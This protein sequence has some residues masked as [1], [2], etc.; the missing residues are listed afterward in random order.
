MPPGY[1][2]LRFINSCSFVALTRENTN[3][4]FSDNISN[5]NY[6]FL[7]R[8]LSYYNKDIT[9]LKTIISIRSHSQQKWTTTEGNGKLILN[10]KRFLSRLLYLSLIDNK[11]LV[12]TRV[13]RIIDRKK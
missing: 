11:E 7:I 5:I 4:Q 10:A 6:V 1:F 3:T 2:S 9:Q 12:T 13:H 8:T